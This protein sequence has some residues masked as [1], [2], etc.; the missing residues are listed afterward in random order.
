[1]ATFRRSILFRLAADPVARVWSGHGPLPIT[2][3]YDPSGAIYRGAGDLLS[4][5]A[6]KQLVNGVADRVDFVLSGVSGETLRLALEDAESVNGAE[7]LIGEVSFDQ[8]WQT[9]GGPL[10]VWRGTADVLTTESNEND[11]ERTR[12]I[13]LSVASADTKR[14]NPQP[15]YYT[16]QEQRRRSPTDAICS[17]VQSI[18]VGAKRRF[19]PGG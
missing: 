13:R 6:L 19:G 12:S 3:A 15:S 17:H 4:V 5:P 18:S 2:D 10:W 9:V 11:G 16:D 8:D 1:M 7:V 14:S